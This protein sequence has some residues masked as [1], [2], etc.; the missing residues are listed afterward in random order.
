MVELKGLIDTTT[1]AKPRET[2][3]HSRRLGST[4]RR[5]VAG[6]GVLLLLVLIIYPEALMPRDPFGI[7]AEDRLTPPGS[8]YWFGTDH[9]GRDI[10]SRVILATRYSVLISSG[11]V[12]VITLAGLIAGMLAGYFR[13]LDNLIMRLMD[14][15]MAFPT[16][17]F[18][19]AILAIMG[20][21][22]TN[23]ILAIGI[24]YTPQVARIT[25]SAVLTYRETAFVEAAVS[26]GSSDLRVMAR[27]LLP[28][29][30][31]VIVIQASYFLARVLLTEAGLS[32]LGLGLPPNTP[33]WGMILGE[34]R[35]YLR[36]AP[37]ITIFPGLAIAVAVVTLNVFG[38]IVRD[39]LDP[40]L[41]GTSS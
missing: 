6:A 41:R 16:T 15:I 36:E 3:F 40:R 34:G 13:R 2:L 27:H 8:T 25:R 23:L 17:M 5:V 35:T 28:N 22:A 12:V 29:V 26:I 4:I 9:L 18:A 21:D 32:F 19:L 39:R 10:L 37:W 33:S 30:T 11:V 20:R 38:D 24:A 14:S 1:R 7:V 31:P